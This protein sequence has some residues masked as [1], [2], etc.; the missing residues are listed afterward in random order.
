MNE[1]G[2]YEINSKQWNYDPFGAPGISV[3]DTCFY[4]GWDAFVNHF[5]KDVDVIVFFEKQEI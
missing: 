5:Q 2:C 1:W 3:E 4:F